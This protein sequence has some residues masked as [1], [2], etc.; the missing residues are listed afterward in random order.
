MYSVCMYVHTVYVCTYVQCMYVQCMYVQ[1]VY[2][3]MYICT[4]VR[5]NIHCICVD[6]YVFKLFVVA[7][8]TE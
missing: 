4:D 8:S 5:N 2:V 6:T 1:C 7:T 3:R